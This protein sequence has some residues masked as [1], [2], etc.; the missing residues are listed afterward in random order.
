MGGV[1]AWTREW[2]GRGVVAACL[3][4]LVGVLVVTTG[5]RDGV[6][7]P[8]VVHAA[9]AAPAVLEGDWSVPTEPRTPATWPV[10]DAV[11]TSITLYDAPGVPSDTTLDNPTWEGLD[12]VFSVIERRGEWV[13]VRVSSRPNGREAWVRRQDV[14]L[15]TVP[16]RI[17]VELGARRLTVLHGDEVL[18]STTVAIGRSS[19]PTP[20]GA[21]FVDGVVRLDPPDPAYGAGQLSVSAFS[22][23]HQTFGGGVGQ[24][25]IHGTQAVAL[26][27]QETSNG[28][29]RLDN[30]AIRMVMDMAPTGTP[31][32]IVP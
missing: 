22:E 28:C 20:V 21:F 10:A 6:V 5:M 8:G 12:V 23:V 9:G 29:I 27:G 3:G 14:S 31:V 15:R 1:T 24:I 7:A 17:R 18:L 19:T 2:L 30:D 25:A 11:S 4:V 13:H 16:N 26:L 32:E